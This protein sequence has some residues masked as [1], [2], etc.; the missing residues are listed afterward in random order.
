MKDRL[1]PEQSQHLI[2]L[3]VDAS[4]ASATR[5]IVSETEVYCG[6]SREV[7]VTDGYISDYVDQESIF[8]L[9]DILSLL[10]KEIHDTEIW[11]QWEH[12]YL[13]IETDCNGT[14]LA[15]YR[16]YSGGEIVMEIGEKV[17]PELIDALFELL[18]WCITNKHIEL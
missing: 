17:A 18:V 4:K 6:Y 10:P 9:S 14:W 5:Y 1:T 11:E 2:E 15:T 13:V 7:I 12:F 8:T 16:E 3:G